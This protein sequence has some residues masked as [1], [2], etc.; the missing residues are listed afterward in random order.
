MRDAGS[1]T[2][3]WKFDDADQIRL[4]GP[5]LTG[6]GAFLAGQEKPVQLLNDGP[7]K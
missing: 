1:W 3:F 4:T 2:A 5:Q 7:A 6:H